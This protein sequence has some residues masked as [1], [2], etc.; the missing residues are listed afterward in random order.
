MI[1]FELFRG[2]NCSPQ[3]RIA[4]PKTLQTKRFWQGNVVNKIKNRAASRRQL[5]HNSV[6]PH[7][8]CSEKKSNIYVFI[9]Q[10]LQGKSNFAV[11]VTQR[12]GGLPFKNAQKNSRKFTFS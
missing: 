1:N 6:L 8:K 3:W 4:A 7:G 9:T 2:V 5:L 10:I 12:R 11:S